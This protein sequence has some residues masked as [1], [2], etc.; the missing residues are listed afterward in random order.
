ML[1]KDSDQILASNNL[2]TDGPVFRVWYISLVTG[3]AL[4]HVVDGA[5]LVSQ[6][7]IAP[8]S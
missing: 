6:A 2:T 1:T 7:Q 5:M 4:Y 3:S 8:L